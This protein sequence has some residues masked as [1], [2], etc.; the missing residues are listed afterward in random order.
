MGKDN[1][2]H[3]LK[4]KATKA[5]KREIN[6]REPYPKFLIV[7]EDTVSG[8]HYLVDA[9]KYFRLS[10][11]NFSIVGLGQD[12]LSIVKEAEKRFNE[13]MGS[14]R[15]DF[16]YVFCVFDRDNHDSYYNA[17]SKVDQLN[18]KFAKDKAIFSSI[19][20]NPCF[21]IWLIIHF[22]YTTK[23]YKDKPNKTAAK[24]VVSDLTSILGGYTKGAKDTFEKTITLL[25]QAIE[26][27]GKLSKFCESNYSESPA[28][29]MDEL[30]KFIST[31]KG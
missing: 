25:P 19:T 8:Y 1:L 7:C 14:H 10:S 11:A 28:T 4:E 17:I 15:P 18:R 2:F 21:E 6:Q 27:A 24:Q 3:K 30:M 13:E 29:K 26:N 31:L 12:P 22:K 16:D 9:V 23:T 20:S 5:K